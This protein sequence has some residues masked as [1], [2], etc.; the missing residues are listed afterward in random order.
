LGHSWLRLRL[1]FC[2]TIMPRPN[3]RCGYGQSRAAE[4]K[5]A[6]SGAC[7]YCLIVRANEPPDNAAAKVLGYPEADVGE[8]P[9]RVDGS[10]SALAVQSG[11]FVDPNPARVL[12]DCHWRTAVVHEK[13]QVC[14]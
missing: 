8:F 9:E 11:R 5:G 10:L 2:G 7:H 14:P 3:N 4:K 12:I 6:T 13:E 1:S